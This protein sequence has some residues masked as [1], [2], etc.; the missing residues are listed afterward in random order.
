MADELAMDHPEAVTRFA[1]ALVQRGEARQAAERLERLLA[2]SPNVAGAW[3]VLGT[4]RRVLD[5]WSRAEAAFRR[6]IEL[7]PGNFEARYHL[8]MVLLQSLKVGEGEAVARQLVADHPT[9]GEAWKTHGLALNALGRMD[10]SIA[11]LR[12]AVE[13]APTPA[14]HS[15]LLSAL[16]YAEGMDGAGLLAEHRAWDAAHGKQFSPTEPCF[17]LQN[18][19]AL[20]SILQRPLRI[21]FVGVDFSGG[22]TRF[23]ALRA[24]ECLD[25]SQCLEFYYVDRS[26]DDRYTHR[27]RAT[28]TQWRTTLHLSDEAL[29]SQIR[30]DGIDV[31]ID[32]A[33]HFG[34][35][36]LV[37]ARRPA[38]LQFTWLGYVGTTG[39]TAMDCLLADG[40]HVRADEEAH[41]SERVLRMPH[42]YI[43]YG[44]PDDAPPV[45]PQPA[46]AK[47]FV[48]FGC[49]NNPAKYSP[50]LLDV[51]AEI[52][53][54]VPTARLLLKY[55]GLD[56]PEAANRLREEL[57][58]RGVADERLMLEGWSDNLTMMA[59]YRAVDL[60][61]DTQPYSG[62]LTTCEALWMGVPVVTF[63]G[64]IF[65][66]RHATSHMMNAG[67]GQFVVGDMQG[68][69]ELAVEWASR[70]KELARMRAE[71]RQRVNQSPL[72]DGE[73]FAK[74]MLEL[75]QKAWRAKVQ[76]AECGVRNA[77]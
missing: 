73:G 74:V 52:L 15:Q 62:G 9:S 77:E 39:L 45:G 5:D 18:T 46:L 66:S 10:E 65:A 31:L 1:L 25:K 34:R 70:I 29:A 37:F 2:Q 16:H 30:D 72:C 60:A 17:A 19:A 21:G 28:A 43:C 67:Y 61:L 76:N 59:R 38:P 51:W 7:D 12:R 56:Q 26:W 27:F 14:N 35:R 11:A 4:A 57:G 54:R 63:P 50:G 44:P 47:R 48:T 20:S 13:L 6:V 69:V 32:L 71:M 23:L 3:L 68:Y 24:L 49:F 40:I 53:R 8:V 55:G 41:Y 36:M 58:R 33:G 75:F 22:P 42:D 64:K